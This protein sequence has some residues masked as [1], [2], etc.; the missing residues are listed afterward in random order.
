M[1]ILAFA[2]QR[3]N[4][5]RKSAFETMSEAKRLADM[6]GTQAV[7][8][9]VGSGAKGIVSE[10][11]KYG[12]SK[13]VVIQDAA[14]EHFSTE[15]YTQALEEAVKKE[16][17]NIILLPATAMGKDLAPRL[18]ARLKVGMA[19]DSTRLDV[20]G[21][22]VLI[23]RPVMAGKAFQKIRIKT[24][25]QVITLRPNVFRMQEN[26]TQA[27]VEELTIA[28]KPIRTKTKNMIVE[29]GKKI[30]LTEA[31]IIVSGG[32]GLKGPEHWHLIEKL[33]EALGAA[34][35]ASRAV[36]DAGWRSHEEQVGQTG[37]TVSPQLYIACGISGA[38]QHLAGMS[39]SKNVVAINSD[40]EAPIFKIADY[41]IVGD[42]FE[43]LPVLTEQAA[44][45]KAHK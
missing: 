22:K 16:N 28:L 2:E 34:N 45:M 36:V 39:S 6:L 20:E 17:A 35:G 8:L 23:T 33:A 1:S 19:S 15:G 5:F 38:I 9:V 7:A 30:E 25:L 26:P 43:I 27:A 42:L 4:I 44:R 13:I 31:D 3:N 11:R 21:G 10:L 37:K 12:A 18:A 29:S 24:V 14:L 41:G 40:P 32:R